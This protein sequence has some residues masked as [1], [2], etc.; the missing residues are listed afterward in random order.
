M[1][2]DN[3]ATDN[4]ATDSVTTDNVATDKTP[5]QLVKWRDD[6]TATDVLLQYFAMWQDAQFLLQQIKHYIK[7][8]LVCEI[9]FYNSRQNNTAI[10]NMTRSFFQYRI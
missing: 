10:S 3:V 7:L 1:A 5:Q 8:L 2:T 9:F 6:L 4:V